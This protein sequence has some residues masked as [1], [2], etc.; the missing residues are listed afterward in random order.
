MRRLLATMLFELLALV[1]VM[2]QDSLSVHLKGRVVDENGDPVSMCMVRVEGQAAGTT[3]N[4]D[5]EYKLD[6]QS[7]DS[8]VI[9]Y[10]MF[11]FER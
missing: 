11:G 5:G 3:A 10:N 9:L 6:F 4:L 1:T 7:T 8:A 2:A